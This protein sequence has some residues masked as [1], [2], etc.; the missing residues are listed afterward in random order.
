MEPDLPSEHTIEKDVVRRLKLLIAKGAGQ[1]AIDATL[2]EEV[3]RPV[4]LLK[5]KKKRTCI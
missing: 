1:V 3:D 2:L 5:C 4:A